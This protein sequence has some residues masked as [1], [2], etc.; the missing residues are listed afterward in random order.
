MP[1]NNEIFLEFWRDYQWPEATILRF[2]LYHDDQGVPVTYTHEDLPG[3]YITVTPEQFALADMRVRVRD[4][5]LIPAAR[6]APPKL[7]PGDQGTACD[8]SDVCVIQDP[9]RLATFWRLRAHETH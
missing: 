9:G 1:D 4:S 3:A 5:Q 8:P 2:R 6:P 7:V